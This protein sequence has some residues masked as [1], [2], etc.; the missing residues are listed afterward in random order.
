MGKFIDLLIKDVEIRE[1]DT[2]QILD[3]SRGALVI[4]LGGS[5]VVS[6]KAKD[7]V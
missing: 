7:V 4:F 5:T 1:A 6:W 3:F 2:C